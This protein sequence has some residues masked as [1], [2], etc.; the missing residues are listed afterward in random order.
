MWTSTKWNVTRNA[1]TCTLRNGSERRILN[2]DRSRIVLVDVPNSLGSTIEE[3]IE[4]IKITFETVN[5][6][7]LRESYY[8][9][10]CSESTELPSP[11]S[12][13]EIKVLPN[14]VENYLPVMGFKYHS[15][16]DERFNII[17]QSSLPDVLEYTPRVCFWD[18]EVQVPDDKSFPSSSVNPI[19]M[20]SLATNY[21]SDVELFTTLPQAYIKV[22][23]AYHFETEKEMLEY[24]FMRLN[25]NDVDVGYWSSGFDWPYLI[26]R[27]RVLGSNVIEQ[28]SGKVEYFIHDSGWTQNQ[29]EKVESP[30]LDHFDLLNFMRVAYPHLKSHK[31]DIVSDYLLGKKKVDVDINEL[32]KLSNLPEEPTQETLELTHK[33]FT[34]SIQDTFLLKELWKQLYRSIRLIVDVTGVPYSKVGTREDARAFIS[35]MMPSLLFGNQS[36]ETSR[37]PHSYMEQGLYHDVYYYSHMHL[38]IDAM[39]N[40]EDA[41]TRDVGKMFA[42]YQFQ[43]V[44][45]ELFLHPKLKPNRILEY[46]NIIGIN[47]NGSY[48]KFKLP[49]QENAYY[50]HF[51]SVATGS[52]IG[53]TGDTFEYHGPAYACKH[54]FGL[55]KKG[56]E[57]FINSVLSGVKEFN[58]REYIQQIPVLREDLLMETKVT[59]NNL[60]KYERLLTDKQREK[61]AQDP[62]TWVKVKYY[63]VAN[64]EMR[65]PEQLEADQTANVDL[66]YYSS[67]L[68]R[69]LSQL[70][71]IMFR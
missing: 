16:F 71:K 54:P 17:S 42:N 19:T 34:Y 1:L 22:P 24:L 47:T 8:W 33:F 57:L 28:C 27:L 3:R 38:M 39:K 69:I 56:V 64:K 40:S 6:V 52:W 51:I 31:L 43:W 53:K 14:T 70:K 21:T 41:L 23:N 55:I 2:F 66:G 68:Y 26:N 58:L 20:A 48:L 29:Y 35:T 46:D 12:F 32:S 37:I 15:V 65:T 10:L 49:Y 7:H 45:K 62:L 9:V 18:L 13:R 11:E 60:S 44:V 4:L 36:P 61:F 50:E 30:S 5:V 59:S 67:Q 63:M 25:E